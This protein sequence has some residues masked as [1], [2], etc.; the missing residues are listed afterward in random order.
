MWSRESIKD[1]AKGFLRKHYWKAFLVSLIVLILGGSSGGNGGS[2]FDINYHHH[3]PGNRNIAIESN[4]IILNLLGRD[5]VY[6]VSVSTIVFFIIV[7]VLIGISIG[8]NIDVGEKRFF[9]KGFKDD[10]RINY[11]FSTFNSKEYLYIVKVQFLRGLFTIL[12][13]LLLVIP[14]IIKAYEYSMIP[15]IL[16]ENPNLEVG[17]VFSM[18]KDMTIGH[19]WDMFVLDL[20]FIGWYLLGLIFFGIGGIFVNPYVAATKA[21]LYTILSGNDT[22][23]RTEYF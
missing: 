15:Y 6:Y 23:F 20:S 19:K 22:D 16:S 7:I 12:W 21:R 2:Q 11:L 17:E 18:S 14:G 5:I 1:Y 4:N 8:Y 9:L 13:S 3:V 10:V